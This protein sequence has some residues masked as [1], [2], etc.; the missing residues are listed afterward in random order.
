LKAGKGHHWR[1]APRYQA[2]L[3][4]ERHHQVGQR[5]VPAIEPTD[6]HHVHLATD[7]GLLA[8]AGP[9]PRG[10]ILAAIIGGT[11]NYSPRL[12]R[13]SSSF[14]FAP[15]KGHPL[16]QRYRDQD[17]LRSAI[18]HADSLIDLPLSPFVG[19]VSC[20]DVIELPRRQYQW[21]NRAERVVAADLSD[22]LEFEL[23]TA[24]PR[25]VHRLSI[26]HKSPMPDPGISR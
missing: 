26:T 6:D 1:G 16:V 13:T 18:P 19:E 2:G 15:T 11:A 8:W 22:Y 10:V 3:L 7:G 14:V 4:A 21:L 25:A 17:R 5:R 24:P 9:W 23:T 20:A 12:W